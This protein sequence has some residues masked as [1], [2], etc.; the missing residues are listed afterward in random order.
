MNVSVDPRGVVLQI[1][2]LRRSYGA[3]GLS[4]TGVITPR[5]TVHVVDYITF[6]TVYS[7]Q[8]YISKCVQPT[9]YTHR[10]RGRGDGG[11]NGDGDG[12]GA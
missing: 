12:A 1:E 9:H 2:Y 11:A 4:T 10:G 3:K 7:P 8:I 6:V 5:F